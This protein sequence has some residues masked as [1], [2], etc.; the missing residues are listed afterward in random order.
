M[1]F[2][3]LGH[4]VRAQSSGT[5]ITGYS[6]LIQDWQS[7]DA[8]SAQA[9]NGDDGG[10]WAPAAENP[11]IIN[12]DGLINNGPTI[13]S[14]TGATL[15]SLAVGAFEISAF[16]EWPALGPT[17][18]SRSRAIV[19][20]TLRAMAN[21]SSV[22]KS[23]AYPILPN[24]AFASIQTV[25]VPSTSIEL[26]VPL[27]CHD[28]ATLNS[29]IVNWI[30]AWPHLP[31]TLPKFRVLR[32]DQNG[33]ATP[34]SSAAAGADVS[35]YFTAPATGWS[36]PGV[37]QSFV[38]PVDTDNIVS[39]ANYEYVLEIDEEQG[40]TGFPWGAQCYAQSVSYVDNT[41]TVVPK[42]NQTVDGI[43]I[44][45]SSSILV[46][47]T[48]QPDP[49]QNGLWETTAGNWA[50]FPLP[51]SGAIFFIQNGNQQAHTYWQSTTGGSQTVQL[52]GAS[53]SYVKGDTVAPVTSAS[54]F[55]LVAVCTVAGIAGGTEPTWP[56]ISGQ[57]IVDGGVTWQMQA[58]QE[59]QL[60]ITP[61]NDTQQL[62][63]GCGGGFA[64]FGNIWLPV[65]CAFSGIADCR[66]D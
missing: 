15:T 18:T 49:T 40:V 59:P 4:F 32:L 39:L 6:P 20:N 57:A 63:T 3:V 21:V 12:G 54:G 2:P 62:V 55:G 10:T 30:V 11:I 28:G 65:T 33:A 19:C 29:V 47:L 26:A 56:S 8:R 60:N 17:H 35:G 9:I 64:A 13:V 43:L 27:R 7:F 22:G 52:W 1:T 36:S 16:G 58:N 51:A 37:A 48:A 31:Q 38:I 61:L 44:T 24:L 42:G 23:A 50:K 34:M 53:G 41:G 46:L 66:W 5:W 25:L 14:G 45:G